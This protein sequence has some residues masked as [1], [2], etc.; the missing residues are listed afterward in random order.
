MYLMILKIHPQ[1]LLILHLE[2]SFRRTRRFRYLSTI[3]TKWN[4]GWIRI[5]KY[6]F[7]SLE[8]TQHDRSSYR[9]WK[10]FCGLNLNVHI[11]PKQTIEYQLSLQRLKEWR[12]KT[13]V[14]QMRL[15]LQN[16][17]SILRAFG[18]FLLHP[19]GIN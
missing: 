9:Q 12:L 5:I 16:R 8:S 17:R 1:L 15:V 14:T 3:N 13:T 7:E 19:D 11:C 2:A 6:I 18:K 4:G 10:C